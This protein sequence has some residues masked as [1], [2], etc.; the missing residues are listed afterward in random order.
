[1]MISSLHCIKTSTFW[2]AFANLIIKPNE[3]EGLSEQAG[4]DITKH[5]TRYIRNWQVSKPDSIKGENELLIGIANDF[6]G[7]GIMARLNS[8]E[9]I[10]IEK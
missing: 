8:L 2:Q 1:M 7:W 10:E 5:D 9:G 3:T 6:Y 4:A